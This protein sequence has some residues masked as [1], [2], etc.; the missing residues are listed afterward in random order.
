MSVRCSLSL[1]N[2]KFTYC[3]PVLYH[4]V[5][6]VISSL[7]SGWRPGTSNGSQGSELGLVMF[8]ISFNDLNDR[9]EHIFSESEDDIK[10]D[11][12][13]GM[14]LG[15]AG[16]QS[17]LDRLDKWVDSNPVN[18]CKERCKVLYLERNNTMHQNKLGLP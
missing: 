1:Q 6:S 10:L 7:K 2:I 16:I 12:V 11:G 4:W 3:L 17:D 8:N 5:Q 14:P 18:F 13:T 9:T 15:C